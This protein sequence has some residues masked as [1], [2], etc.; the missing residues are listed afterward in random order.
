VDGSLLGCDAMWS[1]RW[2]PMFRRNFAPIFNVKVNMVAIRSSKAFVT[3]YQTTRRHSP[4]DQSPHI[5]GVICDTQRMKIF[6]KCSG[7]GGG[8]T[9]KRTFVEQTTVLLLV[10]F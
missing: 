9:P 4:D 10:D 6:V 7:G 8:G 5:G 2:L 1:Y 3:T